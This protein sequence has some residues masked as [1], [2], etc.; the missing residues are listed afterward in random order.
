[1]T[2]RSKAKSATTRKKTWFLGVE[3]AAVRSEIESRLE[4]RE[5]LKEIW[6]DLSSVGKITSTYEGFRY[7]WKRQCEVSAT[8]SEPLQD[9]SQGANSRR[10]RSEVATDEAIAELSATLND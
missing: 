6:R 1:M 5:P 9:P 3:I 4:S 8:R 7:A 10:R 2:R